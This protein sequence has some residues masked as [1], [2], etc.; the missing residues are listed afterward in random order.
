MKRMWDNCSAHLDQLKSV[1]F[2]EG[3]TGQVKVSDFESTMRDSKTLWKAAQYVC[4]N[5]K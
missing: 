5:L 2:Y 1:L 4:M 3:P